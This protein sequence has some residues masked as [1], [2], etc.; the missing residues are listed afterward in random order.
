M[1]VYCNYFSD[2][3]PRRRDEY[4][5]C[6]RQN[7]SRDFVE[8][9]YVF[10]ESDS[11]RQDITDTQK[12]EFITLNR[13]LEFR[14]VFDHMRDNV[15]DGTVVTIVNLDIYLQDSD[16]WNKINH[17]FFDVGYPHKAMVHKRHNL[18]KD[19]KPYKEQFLWDSGVFCDAWTFRTPLLLGFL[20]EDF[21]FCVGGAPGCDNTMMDLMWKHYHTYS[22]G[23]KYQ[24]HHYDF[25][26]KDGKT[27]MI[28][29]E[30]TD[31]RVKHR[32]RQNGK[33]PANQDWDTLLATQTKPLGLP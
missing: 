8:K 31:W 14:D 7:Q 9:I 21:D 29:N 2:P 33:I 16:A 28:T 25:C 20:D 19:M 32:P 15:D 5:Y 30:K 13:R 12:L 17:E 18:D 27:R 22:W 24:V 10:L 1:I 4:L 6:L 26:R 23:D 3:N 11:D